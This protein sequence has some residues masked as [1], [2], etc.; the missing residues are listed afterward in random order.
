MGWSFIKD[1]DGTLITNTNGSV[2]RNT[3]A[4]TITS[5]DGDTIQLNMGTHSMIINEGDIDEIDGVPP[6]FNIKDIIDQLIK[7]FS[8]DSNNGSG[9]VK[10]VAGV[11]PDAN[12]NVPLTASDV[13]AIP[14]TEKGQASGVTPLGADSKID[15]IYL[16]ASAIKIA[17]ELDQVNNTSDTDKPIST[18]TQTALDL[19]AN[20]ISA[21]FT[22][23]VGVGVPAPA[24]KLHVGDG[25][26]E[27][28]SGAVNA[29]IA[30]TSTTAFGPRF[31]FENLAAPTGSRTFMMGNF[32]NSFSLNMMADNATSFTQANIIN[33]T[34]T[35]GVSLS[36]LVGTGTRMVVADANGAFSTQTIP[37][38][39]GIT[40]ISGSSPELT[41]GEI[42]A[43]SFIDL[44]FDLT[45]AEIGDVVS[46]GVPGAAQIDGVVF[47][48]MVSNTNVIDVRAA[49]ITT[50]PITV[51]GGIY[52]AIVF[53]T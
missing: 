52:K 22:G 2:I 29:G 42:P 23:T 49:N 36:S 12:G 32:G 17:L 40:T 44:G 8:M 7:I 51:P 39:T 13:G 9:T 41:F 14:D 19:K 46:L 34:P 45:G 28:S 48:V 33:I 4:V 43:N 31:Y 38:G 30:L 18:D 50:S 16:D 21:N 1:A 25:A 3:Q 27:L 20:L 6:S 26:S 35:G 11:M 24:G 37:T 15:T 47:M 5:T 53:K 10:T